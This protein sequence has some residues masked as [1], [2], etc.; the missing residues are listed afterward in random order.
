MCR[1][2]GPLIYLAHI[3]TVRINCVYIQQHNSILET[4]TDRVR[5]RAMKCLVLVLEQK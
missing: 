4:E 5:E 1:V 3:H 2:I